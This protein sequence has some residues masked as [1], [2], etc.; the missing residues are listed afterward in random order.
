MMVKNGEYEW[1]NVLIG[2]KITQFIVDYI[3]D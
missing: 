1:Q 2:K 3:T